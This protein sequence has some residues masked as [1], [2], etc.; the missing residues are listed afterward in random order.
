MTSVP[1]ISRLR[2]SAWAPVSFMGAPGE[3]SGSRFRSGREKPPASAE[4][5][6]YGRERAVRLRDYYEEG[7]GPV[8]EVGS[9]GQIGSRLK[10][11]RRHDQELAV[12]RTDRL[13]VPA[14]EDGLH[15]E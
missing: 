12:A 5:E 8:H 7:G 13:A 15:G 9:I 2:I 14:A 10:P 3:R 6:A 1:S 11:L 4:G